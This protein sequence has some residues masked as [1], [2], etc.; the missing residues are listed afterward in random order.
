MER[1]GLSRPPQRRRAWGRRD[2]GELTSEEGGL[3]SEEAGPG[4]EGPGRF[5]S[6]EACLGEAGPGQFTSEEVGWG[7]EAWAAHLRKGG[8][9]RG[10][11]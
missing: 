9:G 2:L 5:I 8:S 4:E 11:A 6:E 10:G 3:T 7:G 1:R